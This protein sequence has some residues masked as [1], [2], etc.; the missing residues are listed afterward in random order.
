M[1]LYI[2]R[3]G[4]N[5]YD[6]FPQKTGRGLLCIKSEI[7]RVL[8]SP[9]VYYVN[10]KPSVSCCAWLSFAI[11]NADTMSPDGIQARLDE[12]QKELIRKTNSKQDYNAIADEIFT[13]REQ[14]S[15]AAADTRSREKT[16]KRIAELQDFIGSRQSEITGFDESLIR[17]LIQQIHPGIQVRHHNRYQGIKR[18]LAI[19][20]NQ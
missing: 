7:K 2:G 14:K 16:Q 19:E 5:L 3:G 20:L 18:L 6:P 10:D 12:L 15:Q 4:Q 17:M 11:M 13:L 1:N 9:Y 8:P